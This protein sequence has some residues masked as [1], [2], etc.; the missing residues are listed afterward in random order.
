MWDFARPNTSGDPSRW[1]ARCPPMTK[2]RF[3]APISA[4]LSIV[5]LAACSGE[6][7][8]S[9]NSPT[10]TGSMPEV[11]EPVTSLDDIKGFW[12]V[13]RFDDFSPGWRENIDW[14]S[15]YVQIGQEGLSYSIGCNHSGNPAALGDDGVLR[16]TGGNSRLTTLV[17]CPPD[18]SNLDGRFFGFFGSD[19]E[20]NRLGD[21]RLLLRSG[22]TAL[23]LA[24]PEAWRLANIPAKDFVTGK[25]VPVMASQFDGWGRSGFGI[26][27]NAGVITITG[28][29]IA[30]SEC[31]DSAIA[32]TWSKDG[33]LRRSGK[34]RIE[35]AAVE[36][37]TDNGKS[38]VMNILTASPA[39]IR[40]GTDTLTLL[41]G[42]GEK[43][44]RLDLQTLESVLNPPPPPLPKSAP[45]ASPPPEPPP[46]PA[47]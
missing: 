27:G 43:G 16:D 7:P 40:T 18:Q 39:Y 8:S 33:R 6:A 13:E 45:N 5:W 11:G 3:P 12:L 31:P 9:D 21:D 2:S 37:T 34:E 25:W 22:E 35:C 19:P 20:V 1:D 38:Q 10:A 46:P 15:A 29:A 26:G 47:R 32:I 44:R 42:T 14:R 41:I 36:R 28:R 4:V 30:W 23:V 24:K 17:L